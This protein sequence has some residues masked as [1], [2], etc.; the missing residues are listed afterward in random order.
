MMKEYLIVCYK[1]DDVTGD[2]SGSSS[3]GTDDDD[4]DDGDSAFFAAMACALHI[5]VQQ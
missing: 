5:F 2:S 4:D 3:S 1:V